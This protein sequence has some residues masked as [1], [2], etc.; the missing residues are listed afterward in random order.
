M[1]R[2]GGAARLAAE[3]VLQDERWHCSSSSVLSELQNS[4]FVLVSE[5][6][7]LEIISKPLTI[8]SFHIEATGPAHHVQALRGLLLD[9]GDDGAERSGHETALAGVE[10]VLGPS[11]VLVPMFA[12]LHPHLVLVLGACHVGREL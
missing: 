7:L 4:V 8:H 1:G 10:V 6:M 9:V 5:Y 3:P 2:E 11:S 12:G